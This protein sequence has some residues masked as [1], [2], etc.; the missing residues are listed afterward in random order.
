MSVLPKSEHF[1]PHRPTRMVRRDKNVPHSPFE[2]DKNVCSTLTPPP[3]KRVTPDAKCRRCAQR[4][5]PYRILHF[6]FDMTAT[7][8]ENYGL[9]STRRFYEP[10]VLSRHDG[11]Q[12]PPF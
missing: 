7:E 3:R 5:H 10:A 6:S 8:C 4:P 12:L 11:D 1:L 9:S 2:T